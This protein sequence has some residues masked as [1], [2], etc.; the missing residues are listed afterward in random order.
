MVFSTFYRKEI[1]MAG[2]K[3]EVD[4]LPHEEPYSVGDIPMD[5]PSAAKR[6]LLCSSL[7]V[8]QIRLHFAY[9]KQLNET[10]HARG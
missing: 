2:Q 7:S 5:Q 9:K 8:D 1:R 6:M 3:Q 10:A 4:R